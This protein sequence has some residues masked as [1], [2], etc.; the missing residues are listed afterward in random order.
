MGCLD[1]S[2]GRENKK[3]EV[4]LLSLLEG[5]LTDLTVDREIYE[6]AMHFLLLLV[7]Y[8]LE[9]MAIYIY[10]EGWLTMITMTGFTLPA[11]HYLLG[12]FVQILMRIYHL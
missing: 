6:T 7:V 11:F 1:S 10:F 8:S 9:S 12:L 3:V 2:Q 5:F 4:D